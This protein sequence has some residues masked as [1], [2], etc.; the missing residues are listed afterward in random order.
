MRREQHKRED[1]Q[2]AGTRYAQ[3]K[4]GNLWRRAGEI[5]IYARQ[6]KIDLQSERGA[7]YYSAS[8]M[9]RSTA[10][11]RPYPRTARR[12]KSLSIQRARRDS[13]PQPPDRQP[14][15][16]VDSDSV[17]IGDS[18]NR[19]PNASKNATALREGQEVSDDDML[20]RVIEAWESLTPARKKMVLALL[21]K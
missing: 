15:R 13:N 5:R 1:V 18:D 17:N 11:D 16:A 4:M 14:D 10:S 7:K 20:L 8:L 6:A 3:Q 19:N 21:R 9:L 2:T 12:R